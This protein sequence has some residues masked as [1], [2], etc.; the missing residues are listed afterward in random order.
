MV[1]LNVLSK[2]LH[3]TTKED[4]KRSLAVDDGRLEV[5]AGALKS[6]QRA[7]LIRRKSED[8]IIGFLRGK[9]R[10]GKVKTESGVADSAD[11]LH[12]DEMLESHHVPTGLPTSNCG[13]HIELDLSAV[14][15][16]SVSSQEASLSETSEHNSKD[17]KDANGSLRQSS[18]HGNTVTCEKSRRRL[19]RQAS[20]GGRLARQRSSRTVRVRQDLMKPHQS[21]SKDEEEPVV[22][23]SSHQPGSH[24]RRASRHK[25]RGSLSDN[26]SHHTTRRTH[27]RSISST[28]DQQRQ[29]SHPV[30]D[31]DILGRPISSHQRTRSCEVQV[32][33]SL[34]RHS[35]HSRHGSCRHSS[36][37]FG[38]DLQL[39][40]SIA[41]SCRSDMRSAEAIAVMNRRR[42]TVASLA[43]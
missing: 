29:N 35:S 24:S 36:S 4:P 34:R 18:V 9:G 31:I 27:K 33:R 43:A 28:S 11:S 25:R 7:T 42:V 8:S 39:M 26:S 16:P 17:E 20:V 41:G 1:S 5:F 40:S 21:I 10:S 2:S 12:S 13:H 15:L 3:R 30:G 32:D 23:S 38:S 19:V 14:G 22:N 37:K 6:V